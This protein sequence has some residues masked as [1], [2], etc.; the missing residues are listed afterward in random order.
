MVDL[1]IEIIVNNKSFEKWHIE[2]L[3]ADIDVLQSYILRD[4]AETTLKNIIIKTCRKFFGYYSLTNIV[5]SGD[6]LINRDK[7]CYLT[8][9]KR[10]LNLNLTVEQKI[11]IDAEK[12]RKC[13]LSA[14]SSY[15][16]SSY[17][18]KRKD[19]E[20]ERRLKCKKISDSL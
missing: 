19:V 9:F 2:R 12:K 7:K 3:F 16:E 4:S 13:G 11:E 20:N 17:I 14:L 8:Q 15:A 5:V 18:Q 10:E 1:C 6:Y